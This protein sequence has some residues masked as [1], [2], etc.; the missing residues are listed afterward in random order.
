MSEKLVC[1][2]CGWQGLDDAL[3]RAPNPFEPD[4][5]IYACPK[6]LWINNATV[7]CDE[8]GCWKEATCGTPVEN[9]YRRTCFM[10]APERVD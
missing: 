2:E 5:T 9:G 1:K 7:A 10:H 3:L 4:E 6:C 8:P